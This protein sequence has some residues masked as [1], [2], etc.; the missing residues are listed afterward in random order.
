MPE[1][2]TQGMM[3]EAMTAAATKANKTAGNLIPSRTTS[4]RHLASARSVQY[5]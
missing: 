1:M 3:M 4:R 2:I 5:F